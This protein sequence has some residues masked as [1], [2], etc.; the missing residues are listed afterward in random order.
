MQARSVTRG[1]PATRGAVASRGVPAARGGARSVIAKPLS[2]VVAKPLPPAI[3]KSSGIPAAKPIAA[4]MITV[5]HQTS[6]AIVAVLQAVALPRIQAYLQEKGFEIDFTGLF[7][8]TD[9]TIQH[10][11]VAAAKVEIDIVNGCQRPMGERSDRKDEPCGAKVYKNQYTGKVAKMCKKCMGMASS[12]QWATALAEELGLELDD[13]TAG[14]EL[15]WGKSTSPKTNAQFQ[16]PVQQ[17]YLPQQYQQQ[18]Y[19]PQQYQQQQFQQ[20]PPMSVAG[21][22]QQQYPPQQ[23]TPHQ[24]QST[25]GAIPAPKFQRS[26]MVPQQGV[27]QGAQQGAQINQNHLNRMGDNL[28]EEEEQYEEEFV[29]EGEEDPMEVEE[30]Q[31]V[32]EE[33]PAAEEEP[34]E[35]QEEEN[36]VEEEPAVEENQVKEEEAAEE[37]EQQ[38]KE[39]QV[40]EEDVKPTRPSLAVSRGA[41]Q[42]RNS[43][44]TRAGV[45]FSDTTAGAPARS[46]PRPN[47]GAS[48]TQNGSP[49]SR[50]ATS[51]GRGL[52]R[53]S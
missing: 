5:S 24:F 35:E 8:Q 53:M 48:A 44:S 39:E 13:I 43:P 21:A 50:G 9:I 32:E 16:Y 46:I 23:R 12:G 45:T 6:E 31:V 37:K 40:K 26:G 15:K 7:E 51:R 36:P 25:R 1:V 22:P 42:G 10:K 49:A 17:Q 47:R 27:R 41:H 4:K 52:N 38:V 33:E 28:I 30:E 3:V 2:S 14:C 11:Q 34:V 19:P 18:Q 20:G 29:E